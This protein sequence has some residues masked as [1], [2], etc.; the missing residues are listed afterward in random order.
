MGRELPGKV[1]LHCGRSFS[2]RKK[3]EG[4]WPE[5][6]YCSE[7]CRRTARNKIHRDYE[8]AILTLLEERGPGKSICPSEAARLVH[9]EEKGWREAMDDVRNAAR[10]LARAGQI[11]I[12]RK[13]QPIDPD[14][15]RGVVRLAVRKPQ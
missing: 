3:W 9:P 2:W 7:R 4:N 13:G 5:V 14:E 8:A 6:K 11:C 15:M 10:R 12:T 1:C